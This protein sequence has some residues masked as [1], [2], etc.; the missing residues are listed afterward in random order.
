MIHTFLALGAS[1]EEKDEQGNTLLMAAV[2]NGKWYCVD[3]CLHF[4]A[5]VDQVDA[6]GRTAL[7]LAVA[8]DDLN[9]INV[10]LQNDAR[11]DL[12]D[13]E[14]RTAADHATGKPF[15]KRLFERKRK[16]RRAQQL[17]SRSV[18][19]ASASLAQINPKA[20]PQASRQTGAQADAPAGVERA[21][22]PAEKPAPGDGAQ[23]SSPT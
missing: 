15:L 12:V 1:I 4:N 13:N 2:S 10:L 9:M 23:R 22:P 11:L 21:R 18:Q 19:G 7:M 5:D 6:K 14:G 16:L 3:A 17:E 8:A 20:S